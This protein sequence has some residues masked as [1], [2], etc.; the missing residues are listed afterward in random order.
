MKYLNNRESF[1]NSNSKLKKDFKLIKENTAGAGP[2]ANEITWG[3]SLLGRLVN[4]FTRKAGIGVDMMKISNVT[5][6][7]EQEFKNIIDTSM[8]LAV[9]DEDKVNISR[10]KISSLIGQLRDVVYNKKSVKTIKSVCDTTISEV[11]SIEESDL[12][13]DL[14]KS[15]SELLEKL[16]EFRKFLDQF[17]DDDKKDDDKKDN[18]NKDIYSNYVDNFKVVLKLCQAYAILKK[19]K[20]D[21]LG[22]EAGVKKVTTPNNEKLQKKYQELLNQWKEDQK[23]SGKTNLNPDEGTKKRLEQEAAKLVESTVFSIYENQQNSVFVSLKFLYNYVV[24]FLKVDDIDSVLKMDLNSDKF[25]TPITKIYSVVRKSNLVS[26][27]INELLTKPEEIGKKISQLY[28]ITKSK[29]DGNFD[30]ISPEM[31]KIISEFNSTMKK[32]LDK[33]TSEKVL[34]NYSKFVKLIREADGGKKDDT[35]SDDSNPDKIKTQTT[36][37]KIIE[38]FDKN[39]NFDAWVIEKTEAEKIEKNIEK[40]SKGEN[41]E[42]VLSGIDPIL[43]IV[44]LFNRA[45]KIHTVDVIPGGRSGG[46]LSGIG[47]RKVFREYDAFGY[48]SGEPNAVTQGPYRNKKVFN[49]WEDAVLDIMSKREYQPIFSKKTKI[50]VGNELKPNV[51]VALRQF[52]TD[53]LDGEKLYKGERGDGGSTQKKFLAKYFGDIVD[54]DWKELPDGKISMSLGGKPDVNSNSEISGKIPSP[55]YGFFDEKKTNIDDTEGIVFSILG[56]NDKDEDIRYYGFV[57]KEEGGFLYLVYSSSFFK[58]SNICRQ[59]IK[60]SPEFDKGDDKLLN[61]NPNAT[62]YSTKI[63]PEDFKNMIK[64]GGKLNLKGIDYQEKS[65]EVIFN[66]VERRYIL[67][68]EKEGKFTNLLVKDRSTITEWYNKFNAGPKD[69]KIPESTRK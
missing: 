58:I 11:E 60:G 56:K 55:K 65:T 15:K 13:T 40:Y 61:Q 47:G 57:R 3:D 49:I 5:S 8:V 9:N 53:M 43:N 50:Q 30:G 66:N 34:T 68:N 7:L 54:T 33:S 46:S 18:E 27:N 1:L 41:K 59:S 19:S 69:D 10:L 36:S 37:D 51:G 6:K 4:H 67:S 24:S 29:P 17:K 52:M 2:F 31:Q 39:M 38:Y 28:S 35:K 23:K 64:S 62:L 14:N 20:N 22:T 44:K 12:G 63:K 32:C 21:N 45:Y 42:I 48:T 26:E 16:K 25:K